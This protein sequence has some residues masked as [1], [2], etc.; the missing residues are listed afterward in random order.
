EVIEEGRPRLAVVETCVE[1]HAFLV[2]TLTLAIRA[3]GA[4]IDWTV[5]PVMRVK[6]DAGGSVLAIGDTEGAVIESWIHIE[7]E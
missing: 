4:A 1:D 6:R 2:D 3:A 5:H 7:C